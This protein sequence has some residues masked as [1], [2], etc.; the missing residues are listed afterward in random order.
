[1]IFYFSATGNCRHTAEK[2]AAATGDTA[3]SVK[4]C[5]ADG[6]F[7]FDAEE[8]LGIVSPTYAWGLPDLVLE[9]LEKLQINGKPEYTYFVATYATTP[10]HGGYFASRLVPIDGFFSVQ[11]PNTW[12]PMSDLSDSQSVAEMN[13]MADR[14]IEARIRQIREKPRGNFMRDRVPPFTRLLC[15]PYYDNMRK[16]KNFRVEDTCNGCSLCAKDCPA[17]AI[18]MRGGNPFWVKERCTMCLSCL[19]HCPNFAIQYGKNTKG[20]GQ[21]THP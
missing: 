14:E 3:I 10:G 4:D 9:F 20:H 13:R 12:T 11:M 21:Y 2:I 17:R 18:E 8:Y 16:T 15:K 1:M 6:S 5:L 7:A 19:H